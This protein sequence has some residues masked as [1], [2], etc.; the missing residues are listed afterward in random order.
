L[1]PQADHVENSGAMDQTCGQS[2][3]GAG[4]TGHS[5]NAMTSDGQRRK[6]DL[7]RERICQVLEDHPELRKIA[8]G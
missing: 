5:S 2:F 8:E 6:N 1:F 7:L 4:K 3:V